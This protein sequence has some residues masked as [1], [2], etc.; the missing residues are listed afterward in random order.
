M[1]A[2]V[3]YE[4]N[5][6]TQYPLPD[7]LYQWLVALLHT[8]QLAACSL[9][10]LPHYPSVSLLLL[11]RVAIKRA[12]ALIETTVIS[13]SAECAKVFAMAVWRVTTRVG[14]KILG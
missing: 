6:L 1:P 5:T 2:Y 3:L 9:L 4:L 11:P 14:R 7:L 12:R 10:L 13:G 8:A